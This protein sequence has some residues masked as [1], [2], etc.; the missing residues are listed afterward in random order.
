MGLGWDG[1][2]FQPLDDFEGHVF[3]VAPTSARGEIHELYGLC[4]C[5]PLITIKCAENE[6]KMTGEIAVVHK[7]ISGD[8]WI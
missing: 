5:D 6:D 4:S 7:S 8:P 1:F 2:P 3:P